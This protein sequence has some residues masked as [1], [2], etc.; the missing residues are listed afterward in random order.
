MSLIYEERA[1]LAMRAGDHNAAMQVLSAAMIH[2]REFD[3]M[4][5]TGME[6]GTCPILSDHTEDQRDNR[7]EDWSMTDDVKSCAEGRIFDLLRGRE[8]FNRIYD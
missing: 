5:E 1:K 4:D 8:D 2:A 6:R 3:K 7:K